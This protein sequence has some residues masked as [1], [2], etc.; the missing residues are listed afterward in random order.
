MDRLPRRGGLHQADPAGGDGF[1][2]VPLHQSSLQGVG[3]ISRPWWGGTH[4]RP[5][6]SSRTASRP[7]PGGGTHPHAPTSR[8][9]PSSGSLDVVTVSRPRSWPP[10]PAPLHQPPLQGVVLEASEIHQRATGHVPLN[11]D[12]LYSTFRRASMPDPSE[13]LASPLSVQLTATEKQAL[14]LLASWPLCSTEQLADLMGGVTFRR[15][16]QMLLSLRKR[17]LVTSELKRHG[18]TDDGLRCQARRD[19]ASV[20]M[21]LAGGVPVTATKEKM[22]TLRPTTGLPFA[23]LHPRCATT[24]QS[25]ASSRQSPQRLARSKA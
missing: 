5:C 20:S 3:C 13:K 19:R 12:G 11:P 6:S 16:S 21:I 17:S 9:R 18:L 4:P 22:E 14:D 2:G 8:P 25:P 10:S 23:P 1:E 7:R 24:T 15:A